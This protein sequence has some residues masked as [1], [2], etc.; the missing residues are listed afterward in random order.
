MSKRKER[1]GQRLNREL[2]DRARQQAQ[3]IE[4]EEAVDEGKVTEAIVT[5]PTPTSPQSSSGR[6]SRR[7]TVH[8][9]RSRNEEARKKSL[10]SEDIAYLLANPTKTV[11]E[12][13]LHAQYGF[14]LADLRS[15]GVLAAASFGVLIL[16]AFVL[17]H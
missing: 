1:S 16:L 8:R 10:S 11:T 4:E 5:A 17:P 6:V 3:A 14:V 9:I 12:E 13:Q 2:L 7:S 15:M